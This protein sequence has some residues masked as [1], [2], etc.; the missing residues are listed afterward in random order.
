M[1]WLIGIIC[2]IV[3]ILFWRIFLPLALLA[4][5]GVGVFVVYEKSGTDRREREIRKK[6]QEVQ[7]QIAEAKAKA[8]AGSTEH[9]WTVLTEADPAS[10]E[11]IPR[12]ARIKS[13]DGLCALQIEQRIDT[14]R[15]AGIYCRLLKLSP[16]PDIEVKFD[17]YPTS[18]KMQVE[19]FSGG[20]DI[21]LSSYQYGNRLPYDE[22]LQRLARGKNVALQLNVEGGGAHWIR[23]SLSESRPALVSIGAIAPNE[24][25]AQDNAKEEKESQARSH[26]KLDQTRDKPREPQQARSDAGNPHGHYVGEYLVCD[27]GYK[28]QGSKCL[29]LP[30]L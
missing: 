27:N 19:E 15:L 6:E 30:P 1:G 14:T 20:D 17:N 9:K 16:Y 13:E 2:L 4:A 23:F 5:V 21:Y 11:K 3:V 12:I 28:A 7:L 29:R 8:T 24:T 26:E 10:G 18:N 22:F 25:V